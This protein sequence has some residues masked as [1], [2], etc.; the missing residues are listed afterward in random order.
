MSVKTYGGI[1]RDAIR[2]KGLSLEK[3]AKAAGTYK[4]YLSGICSRKINPPSPKLTRKLCKILGLDVNEMLGRA[5]FEK[6][7]KGIPYAVIQ[8]LIIDSAEEGIYE[9]PGQLSCS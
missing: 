6:L 1:L 9:A 2:A 3:T 8:G 7:E 4:G 5:D